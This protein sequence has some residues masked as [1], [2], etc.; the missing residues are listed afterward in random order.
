MTRKREPD[1]EPSRYMT[2]QE[3]AR[4][5]QVSVE[6]IRE[7]ALAP[8]SDGLTVVNVGNGTARAQW[9]VLRASFHDYCE[10][11]ERAAATRFERAS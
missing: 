7:K 3:V 6:S 9:R 1:T 11:I 8:G 10:R 5:L 4:E 2:F